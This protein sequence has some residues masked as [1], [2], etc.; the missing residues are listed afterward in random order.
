MIS[1]TVKS[2]IVTPADLLHVW[3][4]GGAEDG[5]ADHGVRALALRGGQ[6]LARP[7]PRRLALEHCRHGLGK[8]RL[9]LGLRSLGGNSMISFGLFFGQLSGQDCWR[10]FDPFLKKFIPSGFKK[11]NTG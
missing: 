1:G 5:A 10:F 8:E 11:F 2:G 9:V 3:H 7:D 4:N 6:V